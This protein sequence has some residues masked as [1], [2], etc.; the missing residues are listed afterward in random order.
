MDC[1]SL[2]SVTGK[3]AEVGAV[4]RRQGVANMCDS[5]CHLWPANLF[6]EIAVQLVGNEPPARTQRRDGQ[7]HQGEQNGANRQ[8]PPKGTANAARA[9]GN[10]ACQPGLG[11][12]GT[13]GEEQ[14]ISG[15]QIVVASLRKDE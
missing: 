14:G 8:S 5:G 12:N 9:G 2:A 15:G 11:E 6:V 13:G 4:V 10:K 1:A 7:E 3:N